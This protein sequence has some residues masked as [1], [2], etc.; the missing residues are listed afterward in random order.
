MDAAWQS[1][2]HQLWVK[3]RLGGILEEIER[4]MTDGHV[5]DLEWWGFI[6]QILLTS[7][8]VHS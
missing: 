3:S 2:R 4:V 7:F 1:P 5:E 8:V 6:C